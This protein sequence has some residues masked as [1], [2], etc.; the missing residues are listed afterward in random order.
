MNNLKTLALAFC[1]TLIT[2][3]AFAEKRIGLSASYA[4]FET[5]G[6]ETLRSTGA[7]TNHTHSDEVVVP[8]VF[9]EVVND[10]GLGLGLDYVPVAEI[11]SNSKS[12]TDKLTAGTTTGTSKASAELASHIT[13]YAISE[14][15]NGFYTKLGV[16]FADVDTT[17]TLHT[18]STYGNA[19]VTGMMVAVG[20]TRDQGNYF[21]RGDLSYTDYTDVRLK[22]DGSNIVDADV[23]ST[24]FTVSIGKAF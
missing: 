15:D 2:T 8:S 22:S 16:S 1:V 23:D 3:A 14:F 5:V 18:G 10:S 7:V 6:K 13:L 9:I 20:M 24:A 12:K 11:G 17:E 4:M 21:V 19:S